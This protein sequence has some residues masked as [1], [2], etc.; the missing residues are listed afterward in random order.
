[1]FIILIIVNICC[2]L[3]DN[4]WLNRFAQFFLSPL[5]NADAKDREINAVNSGEGTIKL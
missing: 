4:N 5:F 2:L 3:I 1:M